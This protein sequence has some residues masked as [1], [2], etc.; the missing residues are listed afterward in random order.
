MYEPTKGSSHIPL[1]IE[2]QHSRKGLVNLKN[3]VNECFPWCHIRCLNAQEK[4]AQRIKKTDRK[5]VPELNY[6]VVEFPVSVKDYKKIE[7]QNNI[8]INVFGHEDKQFYLIFV[9]KGNNEKVLNLLLITEAEKKHHVLTKDFNRMMYNMNGFYWEYNP[10]QVG[11]VGKDVNSIINTSFF[12][13]YCNLLGVF[14]TVN[15]VRRKCRQ[16][17]N[18]PQMRLLLKDPGDTFLAKADR[19]K[20]IVRIL[21]VGHLVSDLEITR[22]ILSF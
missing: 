7:V 8:N 9:P 4:D 21:R 11:G 6:Q 5:M 10:T 1:R 15:I 17:V 20:F 19:Q 12:F 16:V 22:K 18:K 3:E 2:L 13:F 14:C